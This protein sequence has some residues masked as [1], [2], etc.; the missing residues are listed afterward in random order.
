MEISVLVVKLLDEPGRVTFGV[1]HTQ[2]GKSSPNRKL[3][4][5]NVLTN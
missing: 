3:W 1:G 5:R 2:A 4:Q